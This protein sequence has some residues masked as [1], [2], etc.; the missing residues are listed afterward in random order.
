MLLVVGG[1]IVV[2]GSVVA[3][4]LLDHGNL[5]VLMQPAEFVIIVGGAV[6]IILV[7][8]PARNLRIL[9]KAVFS[10]CVHRAYTRD[11]YFAALKLLY[12]LFQL[13]RGAGK[14]GLEPHVESPYDS[15]VFCEHPSILSDL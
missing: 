5:L 2:V 8:S 9:C 14:T 13:G 3:G 10:V 1:L 12:V 11:T 6:G 7:S 15:E 4:Y